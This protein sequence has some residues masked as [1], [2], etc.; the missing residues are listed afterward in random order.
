M[1]AQ[2]TLLSLCYAIDFDKIILFCCVW[3]W[4]NDALHCCSFVCMCGMPSEEAV[5]DDCTKKKTRSTII[6]YLNRN[7]VWNVKCH[8]SNIHWRGALSIP[9]SMF[10]LWVIFGLLGER[11]VW[12]CVFVWNGKNLHHSGNAHPL[13]VC[14]SESE[15]SLKGEVNLVIICRW[16][17]IHMPLILTYGRL[18]GSIAA[19][20]VRIIL[21]HNERYFN[22]NGFCPKGGFRKFTLSFDDKFLPK[23]TFWS[24]FSCGWCW[25][26]WR[27][28]Y[29]FVSHHL[30]LNRY[31]CRAQH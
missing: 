11:F 27:I 15:N 6:C 9:Q 14:I 19:C 18:H 30:K 24:P 20:H 10:K 4:V 23:Y 31:S 2:R 5:R 16:L 17:A 8:N 26:W 13:R 28:T 12:F 1:C 25:W 7:M 29:N 21:E 22:K 3:W